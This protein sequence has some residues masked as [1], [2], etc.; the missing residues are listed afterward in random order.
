MS[1][2]VIE[3]VLNASREWIA[4]FNRGDVEGCLSGYLPDA[5]MRVDPVG[6]FKGAGAI[7]L[8]WRDFANL[9]PSQLEYLD[10]NVKVIDAKSAVLSANWRMNIASGFISKELWVK[11]DSGEWKLAQDDFSVLSLNPQQSA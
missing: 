2:I 6:E 7:A 4:C 9:N 10:V 8:F 11:Q 3:E 1:P 5:V